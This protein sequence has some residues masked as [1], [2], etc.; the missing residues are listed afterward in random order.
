MTTTI[1]RLR[2]QSERDRLIAELGRLVEE[3]QNL[4]HWGRDVSA[5]HIRIVEIR[6]RLAEIEASEGAGLRSRASL[7]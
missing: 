6:S 1:D 2:R 7:Q 4:T 3:N 5:R